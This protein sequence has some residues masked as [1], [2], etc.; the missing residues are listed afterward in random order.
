MAASAP[1]AR[2]GPSAAPRRDKR[3]ACRRQQRA[4]PHPLDDRRLVRVGERRILSEFAEVE[5]VAP[6]QDAPADPQP[7]RLALPRGSRSQDAER[8]HPRHGP[9]DRRRRESEPRRDVGNAKRTGRITEL[10]H[11][12]EKREHAQLPVRQM[13]DGESEALGEDGEEGRAE[14]RP[15]TLAATVDHQTRHPGNAQA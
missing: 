15:T 1:A 2:S 5:G 11:E 14:R 3:P 4:A 10:L 9:A 13:L 7:R 6:E 8:A 12:G